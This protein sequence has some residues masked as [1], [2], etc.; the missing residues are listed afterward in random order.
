MK[1]EEIYQRVEECSHETAYNREQARTLY[2]II[3]LNKFTDENVV[4]IGCQYGRT[5]TVFGELQKNFNYNL[6]CIDSWEEEHSSQAFNHLM[7]QAEKYNWK[8]KMYPVRS[9]IAIEDIKKD[10]KEI[11]LLHIDGDHSYEGVRADIENYVPLVKQGGYILFHDY[12]NAGIPGVQKAVDELM[13]NDKFEYIGTYGGTLA[14]F[15]KN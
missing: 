15:R 3:N 7:G 13:M 14:V 12:T 4:E 5:T 1:F 6:H 10:L 9:D 8:L 2:S 11:A